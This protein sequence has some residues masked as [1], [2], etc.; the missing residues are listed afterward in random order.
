[1]SL[2]SGNPSLLALDSGQFQIKRATPLGNEAAL[3]NGT[4]TFLSYV[5]PNDGVYHLCTVAVR[6]TV[7][8][9]MTGGVIS[10]FYETFSVQL[11][12]GA[13]AAGTY[14]GSAVVL[15]KPGQTVWIGQATA[16]TAGVANLAANIELL[17]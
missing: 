2:P 17:N 13:E 5:I 4:P 11:L 16:M 7:T 6:L 15:V 10:F 9:A 8:S 3:V 12:P 14:A 1:M